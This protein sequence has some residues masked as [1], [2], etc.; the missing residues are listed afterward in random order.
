MLSG[1]MPFNSEETYD[2]IAEKILEGQYTLESEPW[3]HISEDAKDLIRQ[4]MEHDPEK[5]LTAE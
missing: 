2:K 4:L 3:P 1:Y 5:R